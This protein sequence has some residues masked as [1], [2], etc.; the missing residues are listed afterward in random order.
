MESVFRKIEYWIEG[1]RPK[2]M[3]LA[4]QE[5][6]EEK[7]RKRLLKWTIF[8]LISFLIANVFLAYIIGSDELL[9][10]V[11]EGPNKNMST[12]IGLIVFTGLFYFVFAYNSKK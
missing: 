8:S 3:K 1:D 10:L 9:N 11:K 7:I 6:D 5:W 2:Q 4:K 12:F